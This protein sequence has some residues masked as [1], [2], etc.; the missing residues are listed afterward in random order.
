MRS[1]NHVILRGHAGREPMAFGDT[2]KVQVSTTNSWTDKKGE[3]RAEAEWNTVTVLNAATAKWLVANLKKGDAVYI[4]A[5]VRQGSYEKAGE[6]VYTTD[7][8][9]SLFDVISRKSDRDAAK[10]KDEDIPE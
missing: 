8:I 2:C 3:R 1:T 6:T 4:E 7:V 9:A 5:R 10:T